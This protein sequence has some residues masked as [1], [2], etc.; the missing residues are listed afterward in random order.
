M[1]VG[2]TLQSGPEP[3]L[4]HRDGEFAA[5][6]RNRPGKNCILAALPASDYERLLPDLEPVPLPLGFTI[7][8][9]GELEGHLY[10]LTDGAVSRYELTAHG[11]SAEYALAGRE[12]VIG[13]ATFM[14]GESTPNRAMVVG[15]GYAYRLAAGLVRDEFRHGR[16]LS[17]LL[18]RYTQALITQT[19][20]IAVCNRLHSLEQ[21]LCRWILSCRDRV[22]S[23]DLTVTQALMA[24]L[25]GVRRE[26]VT[27]AAGNLQR[28]GLIRYRRGR[29]DVLD[30]R[31][32]E[33]RVCECYAVIKREYGRLLAPGGPASTARANAGRRPVRDTSPC[34]GF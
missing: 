21:Q 1:S 30:R 28:A 2:R 22:P 20:Q 11:E 26:G 23:H 15:A 3:C 24:S 33:A 12:G 10:F 13:I 18:L 17:Q 6:A 29:I 34:F 16:P 4:A 27:E 31:G 8:A 14:G 19:G 25:L 5:D 9:P 7:H 32:L